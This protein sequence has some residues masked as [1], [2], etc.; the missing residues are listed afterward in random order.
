MVECPEEVPISK[1]EVKLFSN[2]SW[3]KASPSAQGIFQ[4]CQWF[5]WVS[6][7]CFVGFSVAIIALF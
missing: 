5:R 3:Y 2:I 1:T 4:S 6:K 7:N